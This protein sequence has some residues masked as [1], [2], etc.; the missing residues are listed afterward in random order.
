LR[1]LVELLQQRWVRFIDGER[2]PALLFLDGDGPAFL[3]NIY[4]VTQRRPRGVAS[5][6]LKRDGRAIMHLYA[7][8]CT[9]S[10]DIEARFAAGGSLSVIEVESLARACHLRYETLT[11]SLEKDG[12]RAARSRTLPMSGASE[13]NIDTAYFSMTVIAEYLNWLATMTIHRSDKHYIGQHAP[14]LYR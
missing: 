6:T 2:F 3:P 5:N 1:K 12:T 4:L 9:E 10:V 7:W 11:V 8:A 14:E 13:V